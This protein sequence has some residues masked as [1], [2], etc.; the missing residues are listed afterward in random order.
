M[1]GSVAPSISGIAICIPACTGLSPVL[2]STSRDF[3]LNPAAFQNPFVGTYGNCGRNNLRGPRRVN[4]DFSAI[5]DFR[6]GDK[7][8]QFRLEAF[9]LLNRPNFADPNLNMAQ[10]NW[11]D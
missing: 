9:N 4:L 7:N 1:K 6:F 2:D 10:S 3:Y 8:L 11:K 5:K